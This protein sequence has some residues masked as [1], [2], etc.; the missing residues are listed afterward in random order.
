MLPHHITRSVAGE[1]TEELTFS[2]FALDPSFKAG[3][4]D[5]R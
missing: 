5:Q 2:S 4:F 1:V 3:T